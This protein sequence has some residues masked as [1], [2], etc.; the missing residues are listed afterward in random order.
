MN[1]PPHSA[2]GEAEGLS[3]SAVCGFHQCDNHRRQFHDGLAETMIST[4]VVVS[5][6]FDDSR[7]SHSSTINEGGRN[8]LSVRP[9]MPEGSPSTTSSSSTFQV[10]RKT[11][12]VYESTTKRNAEDSAMNQSVIEAGIRSSRERRRFGERA[13]DLHNDRAKIH[14]RP[15]RSWNRQLLKRSRRCEPIATLEGQRSV[16]SDGNQRSREPHTRQG[17]C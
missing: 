13:A 12:G 6:D 3:L 7:F 8:D 11:R 9:F 10:N 4:I 5:A 2:D 15:M 1:R 16:S 17:C 14:R